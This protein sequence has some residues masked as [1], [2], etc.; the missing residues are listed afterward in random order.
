MSSYSIHIADTPCHFEIKK[1]GAGD[2]PVYATESF[3]YGCEFVGEDSTLAIVSDL[4]TCEILRISCTG[5]FR[6]M[7]MEYLADYYECDD[8]RVKPKASFIPPKGAEGIG[9]D[10]YCDYT[11]YY[12]K[13][14]IKIPLE[15]GEPCYRY[16]D[17]RLTIYYDDDYKLLT[18]FINNLAKEEYE[19]L[20]ASKHKP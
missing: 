1:E 20:A 6:G 10:Y 3:F 13:E 5:V 19:S 12:S 2:V 14:C 15:D 18:I 7:E 11:L 16:L 9:L 8:L 4:R 17:D